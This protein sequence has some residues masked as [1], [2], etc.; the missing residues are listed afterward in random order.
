M[1]WWAGGWDTGRLGGWQSFVFILPVLFVARWTDFVKNEVLKL[2]SF[3]ILSGR[4][5]KLKILV[6]TP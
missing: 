6:L 5:L 1:V 3:M 2:R 4:L